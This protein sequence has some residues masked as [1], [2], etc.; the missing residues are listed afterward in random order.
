MQK[1]H[2]KQAGQNTST[3]TLLLHAAFTSE[4]MTVRDYPDIH[5]EPRCS[6]LLQKNNTL[7]IV[8]SVSL[9]S[10]LCTTK[11]VSAIILGHLTVLPPQ[12]LHCPSKKKKVFSTSDSLKHC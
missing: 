1:M 10:T 2:L 5:Q 4:D 7:H 8:G 6:S 3:A 12:R 11:I 9:K